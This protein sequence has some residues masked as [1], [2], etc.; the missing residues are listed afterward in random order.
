MRVCSSIS[1]QAIIG[2]SKFNAKL[3]HSVAAFFLLDKRYARRDAWNVDVFAAHQ[4][5]LRE[6]ALTTALPTSNASLPARD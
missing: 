3:P 5:F 6:C 1:S 2:A 4:D